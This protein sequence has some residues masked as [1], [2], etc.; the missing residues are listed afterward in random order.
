M[1]EN[2]G[3]GLHDNERARP[4]APHTP[5]RSPEEPINLAES[6]AGLLP[7]ED[8]ELLAKSGC[9]QPELMASNKVRANIGESRENERNH[10]SDLMRNGIAH[11]FAKSSFHYH[12][13]VLMTDTCKVSVHARLHLPT[14]DT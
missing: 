4:T 8:D 13:Q 6:G 10:Q 5:E 2:D 3:F 7:L 12:T 14:A 11:S 9:L 1:P